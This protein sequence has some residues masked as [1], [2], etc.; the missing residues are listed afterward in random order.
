MAKASTELDEMA[1]WTAARVTALPKP[2]AGRLEGEGIVIV[3][4]IVTE[5]NR[6]K[7]ALPFERR[8]VAAS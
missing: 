3:Y 1:L 7:G 6:R 4:K 8:L 2:V 5:A